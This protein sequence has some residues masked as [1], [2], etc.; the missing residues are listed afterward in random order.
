MLPIQVWLNFSA[1]EF[2]IYQYPVIAATYYGVLFY[3][4]CCSYPFENTA[5]QHRTTYS[6]GAHIVGRRRNPDACAACK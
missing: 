3:P 1:M 2:S 5:G 6:E 4:L